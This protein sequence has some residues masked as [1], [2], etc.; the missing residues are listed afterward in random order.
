MIKTICLTAAFA[1]CAHVVKTED[2]D[3]MVHTIG[4]NTGSLLDDSAYYAQFDGAAQR[5]CAGGR[6]RLLERSRTPTTLKGQNLEPWD[7]YWIVRCDNA[8]TPQH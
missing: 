3:P 7:Y 6:Y 1:G 5:S 2:S 8:P 4:F